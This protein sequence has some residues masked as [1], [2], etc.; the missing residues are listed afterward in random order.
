VSRSLYVVSADPGA[1][2]SAVV[3]GLVDAMSRRVGA[4]GLFRPVVRS[5]VDDP[6]VSLIRSHF[7]AVVPADPT[8]SCGVTFADLHRDHDL[9]V[10]TIVE[11]YRALERRCDV[12]L[13]AGTDHTEVGSPND[14]VLNGQLALNMGV[15]LLVVLDGRERAP[16]EVATAAQLT[17]NVL[18]GQGCEVMGAI[19][20]RVPPPALADVRAAVEAHLRELGAPAGHLPCIELLPEHPSLGAPTFGALLRACGG[21]LLVG[22]Q[23]DLDNVVLDVLVAAMTLPNVLARLRAS[24]LIIMPGDRPDLLIGVLTAN[25]AY[26]FPRMAGV[27]LTGDLPLDPVVRRLVDGFGPD[28]P[29]GATARSTYDAA[30]LAAQTHGE[31]TDGSP[32][33]VRSA[34]NLFAENIDAPALLD[35]LD[36][37]RSSTVTPTMFEEGLFERARAGRATIVLPEGTEPRVLR[38][39]ARVLRRGIAGIVLL[40]NPSEV[41]R[42]AAGAGAD[43]GDAVVMDPR[44]PELR[45]KLAAGYLAARAHKGVTSDQAM[46]V[47]VD[48]SYAG[49][50]MVALGMADGMVSGAEHTTAN[51][52]RPALEVIGTAP[53]VSAVSSVFFMCLADRVLVYADC[54]VI[55]EPDVD[56][57]ADIA[58]LSGRTASAFGIV[59]RVAMLSYATGTSGRGAGVDKIRAATLLARERAPDLQIEGPIQYDAAVDPD[60]ARTKLPGSLVAGRA[61]VLIFP[62]LNTGN[63]TYKAVQR[64]S[65]A[66]AVG[67][68]LQGLR[69]P[70]NDLS[71]GATV[72]DIVTT[73]AITAVQA[74]GEAPPGVAPLRSATRP[75]G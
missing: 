33:R 44:E 57:L 48:V 18:L 64:S 32:R 72:A 40:G 47:V 63:N 17:L 75:S 38:A 66:L 14:L 42:A 34:L 50:L 41:A 55:P 25:K 11:R 19:A 51:T 12:V 9:A 30:T 15:P 24:G 61:S 13:V 49:T 53:G 29:I 31:L 71:R 69:R 37:T 65:G 45:E 7:S 4:V 58:V 1:G 54:A 20:N 22:M 10:H 46:D 70:V 74:V 59:P 67:P 8:A 21:S 28:L 6:V 73:I 16:A 2:K 52:I 5:L 27:L 56:Q 39:A 43:V 68:V 62:D 60:V 35:R 3:L 26:N 23:D 36:L